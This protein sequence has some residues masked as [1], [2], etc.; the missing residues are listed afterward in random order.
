MMLAALAKE[1]LEKFAWRI[2]YFFSDSFMKFGMVPDLK[3]TQ[4][5]EEVLNL[6]PHHQSLSQSFHEIKKEVEVFHQIG[7]EKKSSF[8]NTLDTISF[9]DGNKDNYR[10]WKCHL[11]QVGMRYG[12]TGRCQKQMP[13]L[14][15]ALDKIHEDPNVLWSGLF[16]LEPQ[17][18]IAPHQ[19]TYSNI[20]RYHL[21]II[22]PTNAEKDE[23]IVM[24]VADK[25]F[26]IEEGRAFCFNDRHIHSVDNNLR[27]TRIHLV[28]D[29]VTERSILVKMINIL[30]I[31][32]LQ[33]LPT[34]KSI[35]NVDLYGFTIKSNKSSLLTVV[36][37]SLS[38]PSIMHAGND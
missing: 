25:S 5:D 20:V 3:V 24:N 36:L 1:M 28:I 34:I 26:H 38:P 12:A 30:M 8:E 6:F 2:I 16:A 33:F 15:A 29:V 18:S 37:K 10:G 11:L 35:A 21:P 32:Y 23:T 13:T 14:M 4:T 19:D 31:I 22:V 17:Q 27:A 9:S 7:G